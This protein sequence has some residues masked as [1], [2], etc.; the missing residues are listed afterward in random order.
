MLHR[1]RYF[2]SLLN[3]KTLYEN[4]PGNYLHT[5]VLTFCYILKIKYRYIIVVIYI[6]KIPIIYSLSESCSFIFY[7]ALIA[8][9]TFYSSSVANTSYEGLL[10]PPNHEVYF[11][12]SYMS[13]SK[14]K[15]HITFFT[16]EKFQFS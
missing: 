7:N 15:E 9:V 6:P 16:L 11:Q 4:I 10:R 1:C 12:A 8:G 3:C 2:D 13:K 5:P 14:K